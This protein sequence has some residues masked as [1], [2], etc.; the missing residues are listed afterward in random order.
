M[1]PN[2]ILD[3]GDPSRAGVYAPADKA[4]VELLERHAKDHF[5]HMPKALADDMLSHFNDREAAL[6][7]EHSQD[8]RNQIL[9]EIIELDEQSVRQF[10]QTQH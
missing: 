8:K 3:T 5:T 10:D 2:L 7:F 4:Y 9:K 6:S 1:L